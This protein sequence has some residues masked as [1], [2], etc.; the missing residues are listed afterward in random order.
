VPGFLTV[1]PNFLTGY[2]LRPVQREW[3]FGLRGA[4]VIVFL[5]RLDFTSS[6]SLLI[7]V[8]SFF[9]DK[10]RNKKIKGCRES[11]SQFAARP[12]DPVGRV[13]RRTRCTATSF[14]I[15]RNPLPN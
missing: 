7:N 3:A 5:F 4:D 14:F 2:F 11:L 13:C 6:K 12:D 15:R 9:L 1:P 10:K 8:F